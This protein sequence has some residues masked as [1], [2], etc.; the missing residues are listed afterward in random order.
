[1]FH[2]QVPFDTSVSNRLPARLTSLPATSPAYDSAVVHLLP[3]VNSDSNRMI[4]ILPAG[5]RMAPTELQTLQIPESVDPSADHDFLYS[6]RSRSPGSAVEEPPPAQNQ[7]SKAG[8]MVETHGE[9]RTNLFASSFDPT[10]SVDPAAILS[11]PRKPESSQTSVPGPSGSGGAPAAALASAAPSATGTRETYATLE[12]SISGVDLITIPD[13]LS[14]L[15]RNP[16]IQSRRPVNSGS[17]SN[18]PSSG[19]NGSDFNR[20]KATSTGS[21]TKKI[22]DPTLTQSP[23]M[24][25]LFMEQEAAE[26][27]TPGADLAPTLMEEAAESQWPDVSSQLQTTQTKEEPP[28]EEEGLGNP[29]DDEEEN[30]EDEEEEEDDINTEEEDPQ[31]RRTYPVPLPLPIP[32]SFPW[33]GGLGGGGLGLLSVRGPSA[34]QPDSLTVPPLDPST[35]LGVGSGLHP[36]LSPSMPLKVEE[37]VISNI[38]PSTSMPALRASSAGMA[39][40]TSF[41]PSPGSQVLPPSSGAFL[42]RTSA[43]PVFT[44]VV[45]STLVPRI[46]AADPGLPIPASHSAGSIPASAPP[47][48][49]GLANADSMA[50]PTTPLSVAFGS[51]GTRPFPDTLPVASDSASAQVFPQNSYTTGSTGVHSLSQ[52]GSTPPAWQAAETQYS[53]PMYGNT[54]PPRNHDPG[55]HRSIYSASGDVSPTSG[56]GVKPLVGGEGTLSRLSVAT[57]RDHAF[58]ESTSPRL[59]SLTQTTPGLSLLDDFHGRTSSATGWS[60]NSGDAGTVS[61]FSI[62][63]PLY[64]ESIHSLSS[65]QA[66]S[67]LHS[68]AFAS[69]TLGSPISSGSPHSSTK[70]PTPLTTSTPSS[71]THSD[72]SGS[73]SSVLASPTTVLP[74][75]PKRTQQSVTSHDV[76]EVARS[77]PGI[78]STTPAGFHSGS[79]NPSSFSTGLSNLVYSSTTSSAFDS[80]AGATVSPQGGNLGARASPVSIPRGPSSLPHPAANPSLS[81]P[82]VSAG[83]G[84]KTR[85]G[86]GSG[87]IAAAGSA[88][89]GVSRQLP[90]AATAMPAIVQSADQLFTSTSSFIGVGNSLIK[91]FPFEE[92]LEW[93]QQRNEARKE[94]KDKPPTHLGQPWVRCVNSGMTC[95]IPQ[96]AVG[97]DWK[98]KPPYLNDSPAE[99][100]ACQAHFVP[101]QNAVC[102]STAYEVSKKVIAEKQQRRDKTNKVAQ[103]VGAA[104]KTTALLT[105]QG[106]DAMHSSL[107]GMERAQGDPAA[108]VQEI[109]GGVE[110]IAD[111]LMK[112]SD[113]SPA[114]SMVTKALDDLAY[115]QKK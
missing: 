88:A 10:D 74:E 105:Q 7:S 38:A 42:E 62:P 97:G 101:M 6:S 46:F 109:R 50:P 103:G 27:I 15:I 98:K 71:P 2:L 45:P 66:P 11:D 90:G 58:A 29:D 20:P 34:P 40:D 60:S 26:G 83:V 33:L 79:V 28:S 14:D 19:E 68:P 95:C 31:P 5:E 89:A 51:V 107:A 110:A 115:L 80:P 113:A 12:S 104:L 8:Q 54:F 48:T 13:N 70:I 49:P 21:A 32:I 78:S 43:P 102:A 17:S 87:G 75:L 44:S 111:L 41:A 100:R 91:S 93:S 64:L 77:S 108:Q 106:S 3:R 30:D 65:R 63:S 57:S 39:P 73:L 61:A 82:G 67:S 84:I 99:N 53:L 1:M 18:R 86:V 16:G 114:M 22:S 9:P 52:N 35:A 37:G 55:M 112:T 85:E 76:H 47:H 4:T 69:S 23:T 36:H 24:F 25:D 94:Q 92:A 81:T 56:I 72:T 96:K 59:P